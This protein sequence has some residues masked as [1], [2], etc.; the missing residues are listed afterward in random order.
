[1][2]LQRRG[3]VY[4]L[5][6]LVF[7]GLSYMLSKSSA[8]FGNGPAEKSYADMVR[9]ANNGEVAS[10]V[11]TSSTEIKWSDKSGHQYKTV[12]NPDLTKLDTDLQ[13]NLTIN[14]HTQS[15]SSIFLS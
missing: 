12:V 1:M 11:A 7:V 6:L 10:S 15:S 8:G 3:G 9:A 2:R 5:L 14:Y 13:K 4:L